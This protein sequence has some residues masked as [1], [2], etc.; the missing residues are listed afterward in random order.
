M[1]CAAWFITNTNIQYKYVYF[2]F[3]T[4]SSHANYKANVY[5]DIYMKMIS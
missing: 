2:K 3:H 1:S 5:M 4:I